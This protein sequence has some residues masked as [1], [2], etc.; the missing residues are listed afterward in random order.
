MMGL[1]EGTLTKQTG[2]QPSPAKQAEAE[3]KV[4]VAQAKQEDIFAPVVQNVGEPKA[5]FEARKS[6]TE[7]KVKPLIKQ[8]AEPFINKE[9]GIRQVL[10]NF[11]TAIEAIDSGDHNI[12]PL[13]GSKT[14]DVGAPIAQVLGS[15]RTTKASENTKLIESYMTAAGLSKIKE[16]MGPAISNFDVQTTIN[17][18]PVDIRRSPEAIRKYMFEQYRTIYDQAA[19]ARDITERLNMIQPGSID[20]GPTPAELARPAEKK[21]ENNRVDTNNP[22]LK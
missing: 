20:L 12:G 2:A 15:L 10:N 16:T 19:R 21:K 11:K 7:A 6:A 22:L 1:P 17:N 3:A 9:G 14:T 13:L 8:V 4:P 5:A 18:M